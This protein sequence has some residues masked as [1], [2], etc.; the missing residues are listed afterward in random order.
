MKPAWTSPLPDVGG[1]KYLAVV[2][3][4][5]RGISEGQL[6]PGD[7]LP[8]NREIGELFGVTVATVTKAMG[9]AVRRGIIEARVGSGTFVRDIGSVK[10]HEEAADMSLNTLP[11][12]IVDDLLRKA[13]SRIPA[14]KLHENL[15][16]YRSYIPSDQHRSVAAAWVSQFGLHARPG[17]LLFTTGVHQGLLAAVR[18][19]LKPGDK[20][21]CEQLTYTGIKRIAEYAN[22]ELV[23]AACD[24][25]GVR[26]EAVEDAFRGTGA[27]VLIVT[28]TLQNP[29]TATLPVG[30]RE[31]LAELARKHGATIIEDGVSVPLAY[32]GTAP[33]ASLAPERTIY[34]TGLSKCVASGF[35][36][37][38]AVIPD[39][40]VG[41]FH[42]ALVSTQW[43]GPGIYSELA[44]IMLES[45][46]IAK[47]IDLHR[48]EAGK[49][50]AMARAILPGVRDV[51]IPGYHVWVDMTP[52]ASVEDFSTRALQA[53]VR[54]SP[55]SH[56]AVS[57]ADR[58]A[59]YRVSLGA[60]SSR[61]DFENAL[62]RL[63]AVDG[64]AL[65]A[66]A[67]L[68]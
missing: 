51:Q 22:I 58:I 66:F 61:V 36:L 55:A 32:D 1:A 5:E 65:K 33:L 44:V 50:A 43:I 31:E 12:G 14:A 10:V 16:S 2:A 67:T 23:G 29:T 45:G 56:F 48:D 62:G 28:P 46:E 42:E 17:N 54:V 27:K 3:S 47:C 30:R 4:I 37:G 13:M 9:E 24:E 35:R 68:I 53:G 52:G 49:R 21:I 18:T 57:N 15:F 34:L 63:A 7:K 59:G 20:A 38:C 60:I 8:S 26:P 6:R 41:A 11:A 40:L 64:E 39:K 25:Q 19:V